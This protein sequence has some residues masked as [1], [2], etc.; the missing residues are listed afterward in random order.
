MPKKIKILVADDDVDFVKT[1]R[2]RLEENGFETLAA[3]EGIRAI[4]VAHK[5]RPDLIIL[6]L[7]MPAGR[8]ESVLENLRAHP[9][10]EKIPVLVVT[11]SDEP[12][13]E[14]RTKGLGAQGFFKKPFEPAALLGQIGHLLGR[15]GMQGE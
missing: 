12:G 10:T 3:H 14:Q 8:G 6:D 11:G 7:K 15:G 1:L 2:E 9:A 13:L 4:E 5:K